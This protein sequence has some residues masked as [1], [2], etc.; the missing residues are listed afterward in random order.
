[1]MWAVWLLTAACLYFFENNTGTRAVLLCSL[2]APLIP[3]VRRAFSGADQAGAQK[4]PAPQTVRAL[5]RGEEEDPADVRPYRP[6]DPVRRIHWKLSAR[7][8]ELLIRD[9]APDEAWEEDSRVDLSPRPGGAGRKNRAALAAA[10]ACL[11]FPALLALIPQAR[12]GALSLCNRLFAASE[13]VNAYA[14]QYFTVPDDQSV[15]PAVLLLF[16]TAASLAALVLLTGSRTL[17]LSLAVLCALSQAYFGLSFPAWANIALFALLAVPLMRRPLSRKDLSAFGA[18]ILT[19]SVLTALLLPGAD[20]R[21]EA[22]SEAARDRLS[23]LSQAVTGF[24]DSMPQGETETRHVHPLSLTAGEQEAKT[25]Q[26]YRLV[27]VEEQQISRP[28][29]VNWLRIILLLA[30][31]AAVLILPFAPFLLINARKKKAREMRKAFHSEDT[32]EAVCAIFRHVV[33]WLEAAH[34]GG[35]NRLYRDWADALPAAFPDGYAVR[36]SRCAS[37][38]EEA[39]YGGCSLPE[40]KRTEALALLAETETFLLRTADAKQ[41]FLLKYRRCLYE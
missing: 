37:A 39:V 4:K 5:T 36:F 3:P 31:S 8:G 1:M 21:T 7:K 25:A 38:V 26:A 11:V 10:A 12:L 19:V 33:R 6:G 30:L 15:L 40:E 22:A 28:G 23:R 32:A 41:K 29:W 24:P 2:L 17:A 20:A 27:T 35:G 34:S 9:T 18:L 13:A 16:L 14:Y